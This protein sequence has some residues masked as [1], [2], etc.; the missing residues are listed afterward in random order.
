M[1]IVITKRPNDVSWSG[2]PIFYEL[3]SLAAEANPDLYFEIKLM[4][5][6]TP[7]DAWVEVCTLPFN[8][9]LGTALVNVQD[10]LHSVLEYGTPDLLP[11]DTTIQGVKT[12]AGAY[13]L[14]FREITPGEVV[15]DFD[16]S[17]ATTPRTVVKGGLNYFSWQGNN[18]WANI[19][20]VTKPFLTWQ[21]NGRLAHPTER[22]YLTW[23]NV[24]VDDTVASGVKQRVKVTYL[25]LSTHSF[26]KALPLLRKNQVVYVP[27]GMAQLNLKSFNPAKTIWFWEIQIVSDESGGINF[28][29]AF[30]YYQDNKPD[31]NNTVLHYR[32]SLGG[33]DSVCIRG[34]IDITND[35]TFEIQDRAFQ[36]DYFEN[37]VIPGQQTPTNSMEL[38]K[39]RGDVGYMSK[40]EQDRLRD[41]HLQ[42]QVY[43]QKGNKWLPVLLIT[44]S[45]KFRGSKDSIFSMPIEWQ[46]AYE[47]GEYYTPD[48]IDFGNNNVPP[49]CL[50][51]ISALVVVRNFDNAPDFVVISFDGVENDID[52][53]ATQLQY[54]VVNAATDAPQFAWV[55]INIS[56][57]PHEFQLPVDG[58]WTLQV[59]AICQNEA[60][61]PV[62]NNSF[63]TNYLAPPPD[64]IVTSITGNITNNTLNN[65]TFNLNGKDAGGLFLFVQN[66]NFNAFGQVRNFTIPINTVFATVEFNVSGLAFT[67]ADAIFKVNGLDEYYGTT[68][69][70]K[71]VWDDIPL[72]VEGDTVEIFIY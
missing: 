34:V 53:D 54:R 64:P 62:Q 23:L 3:K 19:F 68:S 21:V 17:E 39:F 32:N 38:Q 24:F 11:D 71:A 45:L 66:S 63:D 70:N 65:Y 49:T 35:Y 13:Y 12:Q 61:G 20:N 10:L 37:G 18:F 1:P 2:N 4:F 50:A 52:D 27:S 9:V 51:F 67:P 58:D 16:A 5:Q 55:I 56:D 31:V 30:K 33:I 72:L 57:L 15:P 25:D 40:L 44:K 14:Q 6:P 47:G 8:P 43:Q 7:V 28:S 41:M 59:Q 60:L 42:R 46:L 29:E 26:D 22:M 48:T 36:P 69:P